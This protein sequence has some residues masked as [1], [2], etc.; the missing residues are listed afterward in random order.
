MSVSPLAVLVTPRAQQEVQRILE[1]LEGYGAEILAR[2]SAA[3]ATEAA[4][5]RQ[6][7]ADKLTAG[8]PVGLIDEGSSLAFSR[9]TFARRFT[10]SQKRA[11][12]SSSGTY[13]VYYGLADKDGDGR[14]DTLFVLSVRHAAAQPLWSVENESDDAPEDA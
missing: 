10:T 5:T 3:L 8:Q 11:R 1:W 9:P 12:R 2:F 6:Q 14:A 7:F 4:A 13:L